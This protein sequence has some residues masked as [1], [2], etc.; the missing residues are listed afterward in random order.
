MAGAVPVMLT[1]DEEGS[2]D[3]EPE[4]AMLKRAAVALSHEETDQAAV[5]LGHLVGRLVERDS[6]AVYDGEI[7]RERPVQGEEAMVE[8]RDR[9]LG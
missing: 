2:F 4:I 7:R 6:R 3:D 5:A 1:N 9:I 8:N